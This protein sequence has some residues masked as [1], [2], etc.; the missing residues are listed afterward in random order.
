MAKKLTTKTFIERSKL[1]HKNK[2]CYSKT[3][4]IKSSEKLTITCKDHG[5]FSCLPQKHYYRG[6]GCPKCGIIKQSLNQRSNTKEFIQKAKKIHGDT[7]DYSLVN[8]KKSVVTVII[9]CS[10]HGNFI[11][12]AKDHLK[13]NGC[14]KCGLISGAEKRRRL[15]VDMKRLVNTCRVSIKKYFNKRGYLKQ[16][17]TNKILG[18]DWQTFKEH[19]ED[20]PYGFKVEDEGLDLDHI[21]PVSSANTEEEVYALNHYTN[22][23]LL[24]LEYNRWVKSDRIFNRQ[25]FENWFVH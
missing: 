24:P 22:F 8:Y 23:Q 2:Y 6:Q 15:P 10:I 19:L 12:A 9:T 18:C 16:D 14:P 3:K 11:Q 13:G 17:K 5:D 25:H 4:Y 20:N 1:I 21:I 7:Y